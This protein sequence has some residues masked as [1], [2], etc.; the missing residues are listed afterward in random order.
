MI[1]SFI[2]TYLV[3]SLFLYGVQEGSDSHDIWYG[4][5][6]NWFNVLIVLYGPV[7]WSVDRVID[8]ID[9]FMGVR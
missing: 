2:L 8:G 4:I 3:F 9:L 1:L 5:L 6:G 7:F